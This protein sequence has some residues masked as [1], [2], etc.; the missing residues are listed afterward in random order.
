[1]IRVDLDLPDLDTAAALVDV[2]LTAAD[3][4]ERRQPSRAALWRRLADG[5]GDGLDVL[6]QLYA[7]GA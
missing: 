2:L 5:L 3:R 1:M 7:G 6:D 4:A